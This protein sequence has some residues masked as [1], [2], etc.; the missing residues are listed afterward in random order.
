MST[1]K[2][3]SAPA[4]W[5]EARSRSGWD[6]IDW[7]STRG[8][9]LRMWWAARRMNPE[10]TRLNLVMGRSYGKGG[11]PSQFGELPTETDE[12]DVL[13]ATF[14]PGA[15]VRWMVSEDGLGHDRVNRGT[16]RMF[17]SPQEAMDY[18]DR[19]SLGKPEFHLCVVAEY[20][21]VRTKRDT[22]DT[23][24]DRAEAWLSK[25]AP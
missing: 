21:V 23:F 3:S 6:A 22:L 20:S 2:K 4:V 12:R 15:E 24:L 17:D 1:L 14:P 7:K 8:L 9:G 16:S 19:V 18:W 13:R 10:V 11:A 25:I 5:L